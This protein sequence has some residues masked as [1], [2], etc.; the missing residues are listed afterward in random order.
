MPMLSVL[1]VILQGKYS[2]KNI[3]SFSDVLLYNTLAFFF[4]ALVL[5][6]IFLRH[7]PPVEVLLFAIA[8]ATTSV[9]FQ[10]FYTLALR[11]GPIAVTSI[12]TSFSI[13]FT[14][15]AGAIFFNEQWSIFTIVGLVFMAFAF[16]L[17][18][19]KK[20]DK[21]FNLKW[22]IFVII[23]TLFS[24]LYGV[25]MLFFSK[26]NL[27]EFQGEYVVLTFTLASIIC[28]VLTLFNKKRKP[29]TIKFNLTLL[30]ITLTIGVALGLYNLLNVVAFKHYESYIV[31]PILNGTIIFLSMVVNSIID[32]EKPTTSMIVGV[33]FAII[34]IVLLSL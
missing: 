27:T 11:S 29:I 33:I 21:K 17:M 32:K 18:P 31:S 23:T 6:I 13:V 19:A 28:L 14:L 15:I 5:A 8:S 10:T 3:N 12:L 7:L 25:V 9:L 22:L 26:S 34:A 4:S 1:K 2:K 24:G 20:D 30:I 16:Y